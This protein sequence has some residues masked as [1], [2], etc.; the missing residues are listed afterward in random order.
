MLKALQPLDFFKQKQMALV[1]SG[2]L[3]MTGCASNPTNPDDP[4]ESWNRDI[5]E[6]NDDVD[7][8]I[9]KPMAIG[10]LDVTNDPIN[11]GVTN[12]FNNI[13]DITVFINDILQFKL[14]QAGQDVSRFLVNTTAGVAGFIDVATMIDLPKHNEDFDQT[15][16]VWGVPEGP[17]LVLPFAGPSSPRG[18]LGMVGDAATDPSNYLFLAGTAASAAST[19]ASVLDV[20]DQRAGLMASEKIVEEA[21]LDRY[22]FIKNSFRQHRRY[23]IHD[24]Q[25]PEENQEFDIDNIDFDENEEFEVD[26]NLSQSPRLELAPQALD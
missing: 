2:L 1:V 18:I 5:Q 19:A 14:L 24:G 7:E 15:L 20:T 25:V 4:W 8:L 6:F 21:A 3:F 16:A 26:G 13:D 17:Y 12:F 23:L 9:L 11:E 10:Y 22:E